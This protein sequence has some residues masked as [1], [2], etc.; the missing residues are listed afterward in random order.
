MKKV[1][2]EDALAVIGAVVVLIGVFF[3]AG[4][5]LAGAE[6][7]KPTLTPRL[8]ARIVSQEAAARQ[9]AMAALAAE[10]IEKAIRLDLDIQLGNHISAVRN[11][12]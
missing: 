3:A 10:S 11:A 6:T 9:S 4:D 7:T 12:E 1:N 5:A 2:I 8:P